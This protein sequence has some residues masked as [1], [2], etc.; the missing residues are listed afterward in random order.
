[1][2]WGLLLKESIRMAGFSLVANKFRS[3]LSLTGVVIGIFVIVLI[4]SSV[5]SLA[6]DVNDTIN[7]LGEDVLYVHK[8]PWT[9]GFDY[10]FWKYMLRPQPKIDET[11]QL[12]KRL[13][14]Y[15]SFSYRATSNRTVKFKDR[16]I[17]DASLHGIYTDFNRVQNIRLAEGRFFSESDIRSGKT[18]AV[19]GFN[20]AEK[21]FN[22]IGAIGK[23]I[24]IGP[25]KTTVI[26][27]LEKKGESILDVGEDDRVFIPYGLF[28]SLVNLNNWRT[29]REIIIKPHVGIPSSLVQ[30]EVR[31]TLRTMRKQKPTDEDNFS[32]NEASL[33]AKEMEPVTIM[34]NVVGLIIGALAI[35]VG[36]FGVAN[37]MFVSVKERTHQIG[38]QKALGAKRS[39]I[40]IQFLSEAVMLTLAGGIIGIFL[41]FVTAFV[42]REV[43]SFKL[44][45]M[46]FHIVYGIVISSI[47]GLISG[48]APAWSASQLNPV[49][50]IR[51]G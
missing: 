15:A 41:V 2:K 21:L 28:A 7:G 19:I 8:W 25:A 36:A 12:K 49:D 40:L 50:A 16:A 20:V 17:E 38:I 9:G 29:H 5:D 37:I 43:S 22:G 51:Q 31:G 46:P 23:I 1:M 30:D 4:K 45:L 27:V 6:K 18:M 13:G 32:I 3:L 39:F 47:V 42:V 34:L 48:L 26:G 11:Q 33:I 44:L 24:R 35:L 14:T 10:P